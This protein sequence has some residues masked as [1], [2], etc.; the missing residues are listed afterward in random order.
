VQEEASLRRCRRPGGGACCFDAISA[1]RDE[2]RDPRDGAGRLP[3]DRYDLRAV[4]V[5]REGWTSSPA[6]AAPH[7]LG[8]HRATDLPAASGPGSRRP[9]PWSRAP[10][11]RS[12]TPVPYDS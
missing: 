6:A 4:V 11:Q 2:D 8:V 10:D 1:S 5:Y 7:D 9:S 3:I 12:W